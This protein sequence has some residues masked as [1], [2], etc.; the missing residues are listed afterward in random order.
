MRG[1]RNYQRPFLLESAKTHH[2]DLCVLL[3]AALHFNCGF[4]AHYCKF[5]QEVSPLTGDL[6]KR[7]GNRKPRARSALRSALIRS[8][9][10]FRVIG[11]FVKLERWEI[12]AAVGFGSA[13]WS[14]GNSRREI[15][16]AA[17]PIGSGPRQLNKERKID[18]ACGAHIVS[19]RLL[20]AWI[21]RSI[22]PGF[23]TNTSEEECGGGGSVLVPSKSFQ[24]WSPPPLKLGML[25]A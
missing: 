25:T 23:A 24:T 10:L 1:W 17:K 11:L 21:N 19:I 8:P 5:L 6:Q 16:S 12:T 22:T 7:L 15:Q 3:S 2:V 13:P 4:G 14:D 9:S 18:I 20:A